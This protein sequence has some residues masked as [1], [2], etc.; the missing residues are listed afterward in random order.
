MVVMDK[1]KARTR[2]GHTRLG[3]CWVGD[4]ARG[5]DRAATNSKSQT[6]VIYQSTQ[7]GKGVAM[8]RGKDEG[9]E[10]GMF[11]GGIFGRRVRPGSKRQK[12]QII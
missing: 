12:S 6:I 10:T 8:D 9:S 2:W 7:Q 4:V 11:L 3:F 1:R 5:Y